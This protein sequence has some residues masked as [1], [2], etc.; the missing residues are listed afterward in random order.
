MKAVRFS[1]QWLSD[2]LKEG[3]HT[4]I[5]SVDASL[6]LPE[7]IQKQLKEE[8][9]SKSKETKRAGKYNAQ[10]KEVNGISFHSAGEAARYSELLYQTNCGLIT[11]SEKWLQVPFVVQ[12]EAIDSFGVE[13]KPITYIAD[14]VYKTVDGFLV[15]EDFKGFITNEFHSKR[16]KFIERYPDTYLWVNKDKKA[17]FRP[18]LIQFYEDQYKVLRQNQRKPRKK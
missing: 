12:G 14:F 8:K 2:L 11:H 16:K 17:L 18:E 15:A 5:S 4:V 3:V 1:D 9:E 13:V 10:R 6:R 7:E